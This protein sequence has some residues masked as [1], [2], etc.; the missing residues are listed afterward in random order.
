MFLTGSYF[1]DRNGLVEW[2]RCMGYMC[3]RVISILFINDCIDYRREKI[4]EKLG[5]D[6]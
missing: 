3:D 5:A 6:E 2:K 1:F 4:G